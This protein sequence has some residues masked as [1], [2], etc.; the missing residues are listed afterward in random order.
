MWITPTIS[1]FK[2]RFSGAEYDGITAAAL[3]SGQVADTVVD[4]VIADV[5]QL[6][7]AHV[8][9]CPR[10]SLAPGNTIPGELL[11]P[12]LAI[13]RW[14]TLTRLPDTGL[15]TDARKAEYT[16]ANAL[17]GRVARCLFAIEQP[18]T[19]TEQ[20]IASPTAEV[21][22]STSRQATRERMNGL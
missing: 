4:A 9:A 18:A 20:V 15:T 2:R 12:T 3:A 7:R 1:D 14:R 21:I 13:V 6:V 17:L 5:V 16:D 22:T 19:V 11:D 8:A 10:N